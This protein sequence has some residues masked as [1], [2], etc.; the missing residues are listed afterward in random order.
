M[1][2]GSENK[3]RVPLFDSMNRIPGG[4]MLIKSIVLATIVVVLGQL[5]GIQGIL[6][7]SILALLVSMDNSNGGLRLAVTGRYAV[8][9][10]AAR[11][12][13]RP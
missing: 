8:T 4:L 11:G 2:A 13:P 5:V 6:G 9:E 1:V 7:I 3:S 12:W 10:T